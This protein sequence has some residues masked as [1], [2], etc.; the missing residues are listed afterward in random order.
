MAE[1]VVLS[2]NYVHSS[3]HIPS[4]PT[5]YY[6][7][8]WINSTTVIFSF[9]VAKHKH[10]PRSTLMCACVH[11]CVY[12]SLCVCLLYVCMNTCVHLCVS[13]CLS[14]SMCVYLYVYSSICMCEWLCIFERETEREREDTHR[15][16]FMLAN[17]FTIV[18]IFPITL[19]ILSYASIF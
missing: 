6:T 8:R 17:L 2:C 9:K 19:T 7:L 5:Y 1:T 13:T 3:C 14:I 16:W 10:L 15:S 12:V 4:I 11:M 18:F